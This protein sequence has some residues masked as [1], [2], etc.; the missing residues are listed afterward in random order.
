VA[1]SVQPVHQ[2][3]IKGLSMCYSFSGNMLLTGGHSASQSNLKDGTRDMPAFPPA[4]LLFT[5]PSSSSSLSAAGRDG[6]GSSASSNGTA[7]ARN[8]KP[9]EVA[10]ASTSASRQHQGGLLIDMKDV[11]FGYTPE[12][13][14]SHV[15]GGASTGHHQC[16]QEVQLFD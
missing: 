7:E 4:S 11:K 12:R 14:V 3:T 9:A 8:G 16:C 6:T 2:H 10:V 13:R 15:I 5:T 1:W